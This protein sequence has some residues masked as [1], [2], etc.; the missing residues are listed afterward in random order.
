MIRGQREKGKQDSHAI[1]SCNHFEP[2]DIKVIMW[3]SSMIICVSKITY[4]ASMTV[5]KSSAKTVPTH[6]RARTRQSQESSLCHTNQATWHGQISEDSQHRSE[7]RLVYRIVADAKTDL[8]CTSPSLRSQM[9]RVLSVRS[10]C[11]RH[12]VPCTT[13]V[14]VGSYSMYL[15]RGRLVW[16]ARLQS[17]QRLQKSWNVNL[18]RKANVF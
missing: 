4:Q 1:I 3:A 15:P 18:C 9:C 6:A 8:P 7:K 13:A 11:S 2:P 16:W 5:H 12:T 17:F 10:F 14:R